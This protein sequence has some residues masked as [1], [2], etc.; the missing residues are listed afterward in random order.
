MRRWLESIESALR[1]LHSLGLVH[2]DI[3]PANIMLSKENEAVI[4]DC[5]TTCRVGESLVDRKRTYGWADRGVT[6]AAPS[7]DF[8][9][10]GELKTC[11]FGSANELALEE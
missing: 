6:H 11:L 10:L 8:Q 9:N 1:H 7:N 4:I 2:N 3:T 5:D